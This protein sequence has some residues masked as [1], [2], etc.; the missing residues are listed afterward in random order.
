[1]SVHI[2]FVALGQVHSYDISFPFA[3]YHST[4]TLPSGAGTVDTLEAA[5]SVDL[6]SPHSCNHFS[7]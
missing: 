4:N 5:L 6:M 1:M 3:T 7:M 2:S